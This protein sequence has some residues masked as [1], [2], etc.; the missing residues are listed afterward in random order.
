MLCQKCKIN[1]VVISYV[2]N[3]NGIKTEFHLCAA[4][5]A[6]IKSDLNNKIQNDFLSGAFRAIKPRK[7]CPVCGTTYADYEKKGLLC[8]EG[9]Y[10]VFNE[11]LLP[12]IRRM[13]GRVEHVGKVVS[14]ADTHGLH[15]QLTYLQEQLEE[16][17]REKRFIEANRLNRKINEI[18]KTMH[19]GGS[20][21]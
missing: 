20:N 10:D 17:L 4:C 12:S 1:P 3:V 6:L 7:A 15:R 13:Q 21:E 16:A 14:N 18:K 5:Y 2:E 9:C 19:G 8:C 11:E